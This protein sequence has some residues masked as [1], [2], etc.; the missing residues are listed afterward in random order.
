M[1]RTSLIHQ[2]IT[3][4]VVLSTLTAGLLLL[5]SDQ[6][7]LRAQIVHES[8]LPR[9]ESVAAEYDAKKMQFADISDGIDQGSRMASAVGSSLRSF[10][11]PRFPALAL[12]V[13]LVTGTTRR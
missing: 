5:D 12:N 4:S 11:G 8:N 6:L 9:L 7:D 2:V 3:A 13:D 10:P 1:L